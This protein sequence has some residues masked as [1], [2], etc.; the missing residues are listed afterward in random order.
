MPTPPSRSRHRSTQDEWPSAIFAPSAPSAL[1]EQATVRTVGKSRPHADASFSKPTAV[2]E[3]EWPSAIFAPSALHEQAAVRTV[4]KSRP[5]ADST[6]SK[7]PSVYA[8]RVAL[9]Y[10][11]AAS[12][13]SSSRAGHSAICGEESTA[14]RR[15]LFEAN[16]GLRRTSGP[17]LSSRRQLF[18]SRPQCERRDARCGLIPRNCW[19]FAS[20]HS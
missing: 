14:C 18:M 7:P 4:G 11:R 5:H 17:Q 10:L 16:I 3:D 8:G 6:F 13:V 1:Q 12:A 19:R 15:Q 9:S 2:A 20:Q